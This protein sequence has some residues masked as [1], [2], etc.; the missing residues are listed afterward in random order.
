MLYF[1]RTKEMSRLARLKNRQTRQGIWCVRMAFSPKATNIFWW[2]TA[3]HFHNNMAEHPHQ[4]ISCTLKPLLN[5]VLDYMW[6]LKRNNKEMLL[7]ELV[8]PNYQEWRWAP[9]FLPQM[10]ECENNCREFK[11]CT[12]QHPTIL[13]QSQFC[14]VVFYSHVSSR[15]G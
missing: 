9:I 1:R 4:M 14:Q 10:Y 15:R 3:F 5:L 11:G 8:N 7:D 2:I 13:L 12:R 6:E